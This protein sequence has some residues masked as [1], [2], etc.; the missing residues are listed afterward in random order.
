[1]LPQS[2]GKMDSSYFANNYTY[3]CAQQIDVLLM[4]LVYDV[5]KSKLQAEPEKNKSVTYI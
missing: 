2:S 5:I 4:A 3:V 1:M